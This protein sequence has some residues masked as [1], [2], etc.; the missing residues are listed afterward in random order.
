MT[1]EFA[2]DDPCPLWPHKRLYWSADAASVA[3]RDSWRSWWRSGDADA[4]RVYRCQEPSLDE[5]YHLGRLP[6]PVAAR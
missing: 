1:E 6:L 2:P 5:H 4:L 3:L